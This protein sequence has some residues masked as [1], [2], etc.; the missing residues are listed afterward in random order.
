VADAIAGSGL[1]PKALA[2][3]FDKT[4]TT[5]ANITGLTFDLKAG[6]K[7]K[8][9]FKCDTTLSSAGGEKY[10]ISG[11]ATAT[12]INYTI[13]S[14]TTAAG[15]PIITQATA[16]DT[17]GSNGGYGAGV[18]SVIV[19]EGSITVNAAGTITVQFAQ[20]AASG[21]SSIRAGATFEVIE[22]V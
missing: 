12:A 6:K 2:A 11:T 10:A 3:Q 5:L 1:A 22:A 13:V 21:T 7:Y 16:L 18:N 9:R 20:A 4:N 8:F 19:V 14:T 15:L 17:A